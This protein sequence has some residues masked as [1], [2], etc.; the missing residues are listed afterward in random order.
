MNKDYQS[1]YECEE[2]GGTFIIKPDTDEDVIYCP[3][4]GDDSNFKNTF[5]LIEHE[6]ERLYDDPD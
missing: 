3:Q 6:E 2:C 1:E 5:Y 4:C